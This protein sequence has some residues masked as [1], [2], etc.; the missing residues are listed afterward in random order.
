LIEGEDFYTYYLPFDRWQLIN[1]SDLQPSVLD[2]PAKKTTSTLPPTHL[3][4]QNDN[5]RRVA[6]A[7]YLRSV[8]NQVLNMKHYQRISVWFANG[9]LEPPT[10]TILATLYNTEQ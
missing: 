8:S 2:A 3:P 9:N 6:V 7:E 4:R 5:I 1:I 10:D